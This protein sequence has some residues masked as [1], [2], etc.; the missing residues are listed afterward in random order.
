MGIETDQEIIQLVGAGTLIADALLA[1][2]NECGTLHI[3]TQKMAIEYL[4]NKIRRTTLMRRTRVEEVLELLSSVLLAHVSAHRFN[5]RLKAIY[6]CLM[7]RRM[8]Y[9]L[10]D[11]T[12]IDDRDYYGNKRLE[13][14]G[15]LM[16]L[17]FEDLFKRYNSEIKKASDEILKKANRASQFD[18]FSKMGMGRDTITSGLSSAISTGN[19][20][21]KRFKMDRAGI[22]Q[23]L[24]RLSYLSALGMMTRINSQF[25]KTRKV[26]GPRSLQ[27]S[28]W[29]MLCPADT[30]EG[31]S[32]GLVKNLA[33]M[34]H[35][36]TDD[37]P[38]PIMSIIYLLG[39][40]DI[41]VLSSEEIGSPKVY[42][43]FINGMIHGI[44]KEADKIAR[45]FRKLRRSGRISPFI[46]VYKHEKQKSLHIA[47]D[48][49]RVCRP[50]IVV[51]KGLSKVQKIHLDQLEEGILQFDDFIKSGM[52]EY[53]D[54]NEENDTLIAVY[55]NNIVSETTH[56]EI[57]PF[58]I[59]GVCAALI[60]FPNHNQSPRNT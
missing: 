24:S 48:G 14:A 34:T 42:S 9:A 8:I 3:F 35:I 46:S 58:T 16:A 51:E 57:E 29:G 4:A 53:L 17:L 13:L 2:I 12:Y 10:N 32:C 21:L 52:I 37:D 1:S 23:V 6:L 33:L 19:W 54:V 25:E 55:E 39:V 15:Q 36:T 5:F 41:N 27:P 43:V 7:L 20:S 11:T 22:T 31:E 56:L 60:P 44:T 40:E 38:E 28:Q 47:T 30:P 26:S 59:L 49:G 45:N 50:V 18:I